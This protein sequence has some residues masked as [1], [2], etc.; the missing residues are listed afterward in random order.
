MQLTA[1]E[2]SPS[3]NMDITDDMTATAA[4]SPVVLRPAPAPEPRHLPM[5]HIG[6]PVHALED[7]AVQRVRKLQGRNCDLGAL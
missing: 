3:N 1:L 5:L 7:E 6:V 2:F 4:P